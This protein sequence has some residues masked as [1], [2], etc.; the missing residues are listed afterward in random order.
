M[1]RRETFWPNQSHLAKGNLHRSMFFNDFINNFIL[2]CYNPI[3]VGVLGFIMATASFQLLLLMLFLFANYWDNKPKS[4]KISPKEI[5]SKFIWICLNETSN[6]KFYFLNDKRR[7]IFNHRSKKEKDS[8]DCQQKEDCLVCH[9]RV[10]TKILAESP[11]YASMFLTHF[12][13]PSIILLQFGMNK[14]M[15]FESMNL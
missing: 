15:H 11:K 7:Q 3:E 13:N 6:R 2:R 8:V 9:E 5:N 12:L 4:N 14:M 10:V 1:K